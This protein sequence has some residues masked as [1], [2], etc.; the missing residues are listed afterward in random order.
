LALLI[1]WMYTWYLWSIENFLF[2]NILLLSTQDIRVLAVTLIVVS[3][4]FFMYHKQ[5]FLIS[6]QKELA[7]WQGINIQL[8]EWLYLL[9]LG[10]AV[11]FS[12]KILWVL[13]VTSFLL[14]PSMI[15]RFFAKTYKQ[16]F[17]IP[18]GIGIGTSI[19]WLYSSY[20]R[21]IASGPAI[22]AT[23]LLVFLF[24]IIRHT[25]S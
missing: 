7:I 12:I 20:A 22:I 9:C 6:F 2:G 15:S 25:R 5:F 11:S 17:I 10:C 18:I 8:Y 14:V 4:I 24:A 13:L 1:F 3:G 23:M 19:V 21:D 16:N